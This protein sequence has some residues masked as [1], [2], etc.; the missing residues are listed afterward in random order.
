[1]VY[2]SD[3]FNWQDDNKICADMIRDKILPIVNVYAYGEV[4]ASR[5]WWA[6]S[7]NQG[8]FSPPGDFGKMVEREFRNEEHVSWAV[9]KE[10]GQVPE[11]IRRF[12]A[13]GR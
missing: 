2:L 10:M 11:A 9:L 5:Y 6:S 7:G 8:V 3:G 12:F 4:D 1:M 13:K